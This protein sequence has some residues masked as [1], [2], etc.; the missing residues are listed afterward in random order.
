MPSVQLRGQ[1]QSLT[2]CN[3]LVARTAVVAEPRENRFESPLSILSAMDRS[4]VEVQH[5]YIF[6]KWILGRAVW[7]PIDLVSSSNKVFY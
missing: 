3:L 5:H 4:L 6:C 1:M 7:I 2:L